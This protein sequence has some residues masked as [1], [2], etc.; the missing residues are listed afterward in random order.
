MSDVTNPSQQQQPDINMTSNNVSL[1]PN[2]WGP[3]Y[4]FV[5]HTIAL[6]YPIHPNDAIKKKYYDFI[7]NIP[8][9]LPNENIRND[10]I[11][12]LD[13]FPVTPYLDSR[14]SFIRWFHFIHNQINKKLKLP[15]LT[16]E[17]A[18]THYYEHYKPREV[19]DLEQRRRREKY[20]FVGVLGLMCLL[21]YTFTK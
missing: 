10:F 19:K 4:W 17:E 9:F 8:L 14:P 15:I 6:S 12:L 3:H 5:F 20:I 2:V 16:L 21:F 1:Q 18:M 7:Q 13:D 11:K